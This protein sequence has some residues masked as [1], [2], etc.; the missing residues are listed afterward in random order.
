MVSEFKNEEHRQQAERLML[1]FGYFNV[2]FERVCEAMRNAIM[3]A[4]RSQGLKN[5]GMEQV[6]VGDTSSAQLQVLLG[7]F[8]QHIPSWDD[9]DRGCLKKML[10]EIK[11][12]TER[13]NTVVHSAWRFGGDAS[14][15][16][17]VAVAIRPRTKQNTGAAAEV[18]GIQETYLDELVFRLKKAQ[19][20]LQR[21]AICLTQN[22]FKFSDLYF[23]SL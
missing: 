16:E 17:L 9:D 4:L 12:L 11:D 22:N 5:H 20:Y 1:K 7:A 15:T 2:Q 19:V 23:K 14:D 10:K 18:W 21:L 13:R 3:F 8:C 6:V